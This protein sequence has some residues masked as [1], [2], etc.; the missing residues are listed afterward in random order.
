MTKLFFVFLLCWALR[1]VRTVSIEWF[2]I[3]FYMTVCLSQKRSAYH[4]PRPNAIGCNVFFDVY[5]GCVVEKNIVN[6][7]EYQ[8]LKK[9]IFYHVMGRC[10][11]KTSPG[12]S[13]YV[14]NTRFALSSIYVDNYFVFAF[15]N[16]LTVCPHMV[17][18][19]SLI[20]GLHSVNTYHA[21]TYY[22]FR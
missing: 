5:L 11:F 15:I 7:F 10:A 2:P 8:E 6:Y 1:F 4:P 17:I 14:V 21:V 22:Q 12:S 20:I 18:T 16:I 9:N 3:I 19:L 13:S